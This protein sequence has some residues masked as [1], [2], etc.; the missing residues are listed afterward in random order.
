MFGIETTTIINVGIGLLCSII[1]FLLGV[2]GFF[3]KRFVD[4]VRNNN[5]DTK[6]RAEKTDEK[7]INIS[8]KAEKRFDGIASRLDKI[9]TICE[10]RRSSLNGKN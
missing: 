7:L 10:E 3:I 2:I 1:M 8:E 6:R 4:E 5:T 9:E